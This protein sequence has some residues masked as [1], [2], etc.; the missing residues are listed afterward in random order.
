MPTA[1][2]LALL[3]SSSPAA[4]AVP[5]PSQE[6]AALVDRCVAAYGGGEALQRGRRFRQDGHVTSIMHPGERAPLVRLY[7]RQLGLRVDVAW[8]SGAESRIMFG[9]RGWRE[10]QEVDGPPLAA[11][12][13]QAARID[14]PALL[15]AWRTKVIDGGPVTHQGKTLRALRLDLGSGLTL[16]ADLDPA[17]GRILRSHGRAAATPA[18]EFVTTY[19]DFR[20]VDGLL[21][22]FREGNWANGA[23]TGETVLTSATLLKTLGE[24]VFRP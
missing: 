18:V 15:A 24:E 11:M 16:E 13:L 5:P 17:T 14:L 19:D 22:A 3:L 10:G 23:S 4:P 9:G 12:V 20:A 2:F 7:D 1:L 21:V 8:A 6:V